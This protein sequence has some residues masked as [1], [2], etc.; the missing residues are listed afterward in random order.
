MMMIVF[1]ITEHRNIRKKKQSS[2]VSC[3]SEDL[4]GENPDL[5]CIIYE[6]HLL[7]QQNSKA[8]VPI[9]AALFIAAVD[10]PSATLLFVHVLI[11]CTENSRTYH[12]DGNRTHDGLYIFYVPWREGSHFFSKFIDNTIQSSYIDNNILLRQ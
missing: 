7:T 3:L 2:H 6:Y 11:L 8:A 12:C 5:S 9:G 4:S 10:N 1:Y